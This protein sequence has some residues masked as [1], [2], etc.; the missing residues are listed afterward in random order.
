VRVWEGTEDTAGGLGPG[1]RVGNGA[2]IGIPVLQESKNKNG[3]VFLEKHILKK[4]IQRNQTN[5]YTII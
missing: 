5:M 3:F 2:E 1:D 4:K